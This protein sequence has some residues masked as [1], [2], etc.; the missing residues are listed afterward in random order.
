M[1]YR[2]THDISRRAR[3]K[4]ELRNPSMTTV[5]LI[6]LVVATVVLAPF[7]AGWVSSAREGFDGVA[8]QRERNDDNKS[9]LGAAVTHVA[10]W[11]AAQARTMVEA[12]EPRD[13]NAVS[14]RDGPCNADNLSQLSAGKYSDAVAQACRALDD[15]QQRH[16]PNCILA[17][18]CNI[19]EVAKS[20]IEQTVDIM[21]ESF[22]E[23]GFVLSDTEAGQ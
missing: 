22:S 14:F 3:F 4:R 17:L 16:S 19:S 13:W 18:N 11:I 8:Q 1:D 2:N 20:E 21:W 5:A 9:S 10:A 7:V 15:I 12:D 6:L 23:G